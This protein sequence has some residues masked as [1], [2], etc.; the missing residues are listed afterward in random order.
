MN[1]IKELESKIEEIWLTQTN[2]CP[3]KLVALCD[4]AINGIDEC[5]KDDYCMWRE[6]SPNGYCRC[7]RSVI[8]F[9][10]AYTLYEELRTLALKIELARAIDKLCD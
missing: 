3:I 6:Y 10:E 4:I 2:P 9:P 7:V 5:E 1:K 8:P